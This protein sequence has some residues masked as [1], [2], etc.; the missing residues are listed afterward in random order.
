MSTAQ[1]SRPFSLSRMAIAGVTKDWRT[2]IAVALGVGIA[3]AVIVGALL[4]G[5]SMRGSLK[6]L[7][8]ER[9]GTIDSV[10]APGGFFDAVRV[11]SDIDAN[12]QNAAIVLFD[13]GVLES[14]GDASVPRSVRR[15][16]KR[17]WSI[18]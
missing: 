13:R 4:V 7:T 6:G 9:L 15:A 2:T 10:V 3:T 1:S 11:T 14:S 17:R 18:R 12:S 16:G 5:D 8:V